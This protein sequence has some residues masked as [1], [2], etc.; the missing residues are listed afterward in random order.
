MGK[1]D[2]NNDGDFRA[3]QI[4]KASEKIGDI[5]LDMFNH[6]ASGFANIFTTITLVAQSMALTSALAA[7]L[8]REDVSD[9]EIIDGTLRTLKIVGNS[10]SDTEN[11]TIDIKGS[12]K[13]TRAMME[14]ARAKL[15]NID[16]N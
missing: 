5:L 10:I 12:L 9:E 6:D 11:I 14:Q 7:I 16:L 13:A 15:N 4:R 2:L 8:Q 3:S 1:I